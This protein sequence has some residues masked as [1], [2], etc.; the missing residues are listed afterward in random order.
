MPG[1]APLS[2]YLHGQLLLQERGLLWFCNNCM[3]TA[4]SVSSSFVFV[5]PKSLTLCFPK[6]AWFLQDQEWSFSLSDKIENPFSVLHSLEHHKHSRYSDYHLT[7][8]ASWGNSYLHHPK[9]HRRF[10]TTDTYFSLLINP[11]APF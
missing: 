7:I 3:F 1:I 10:I 8:N 9:N 4:E 6:F 5:Q 2:P 11:C